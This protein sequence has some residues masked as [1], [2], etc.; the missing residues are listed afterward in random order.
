MN[1]N[2]SVLSQEEDS[3]RPSWFHKGWVTGPIKDSFCKQRG[4]TM[5]WIFPSAEVAFVQCCVCQWHFFCKFPN[6][7]SPIWS[8]VLR[9]SLAMYLFI[10]RNRQK[11][12]DFCCALEIKISPEVRKQRSLR[13]CLCAVAQ[14]QQPAVGAESVWNPCTS[15]LCH[16]GEKNVVLPAPFCMEWGLKSFPAGH[17]RLLCHRG[18]GLLSD[19]HHLPASWCPSW[20][21][22]WVMFLDET[23]RIILVVPILTLSSLEVRD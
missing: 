3:L 14:A 4:Q 15:R 10:P 1:V 5:F 20:S 9:P 8:L 13:I 16:G 23:L 7:I 19:R 22:G 17:V 18:P 6:T 11:Q 12:A 21:S 2:D